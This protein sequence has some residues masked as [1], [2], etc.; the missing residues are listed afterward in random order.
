M[1]RT[2]DLT[3]KYGSFTAVDAV[4]LSISRGEIY[5]LIGPNGAGKT[6]T[7]MMLLGITQPTSGDIYLFGERATPERLD[8]RRRIGVVPERHPRGAW[9]WMTAGEY[10]KLFADLFCLEKPEERI[11]RLLEEVGL[12]P[13]RGTRIREFSH[14]MLQKLSFIRALLPDPDLLV[15][16]E[17]ISGL[18]PLGVKQVRDLIL[19][20]NRDG[21]TVIMSSH[22]LSEMERICNRVAIVSHGRLV[23]EE[24]TET[25][26]S[27]VAHDR[28]LLIELESV[29]PGLEDRLRTALPF[30]LGCTA[31][32]TQVRVRIPKDGDHR[33]PVSEYLFGQKL[34]PLAIQERTYSL[35]DAFIAITQEN[36][37]LF[38][39]KEPQT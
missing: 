28:E 37:A 30:V 12:F 21:R 1:I 3:K 7:M 22:V 4:T 19:S 24:K 8:L 6:T 14:G 25:L 9:S 16:D 31:A 29:P 27:R 39:P 33:K 32:G 38:I 35:E 26:L 10:L 5:G 18:D 11:N 2:I 34:V 13:V 23:A 15:L 36:I 17:P 20:E